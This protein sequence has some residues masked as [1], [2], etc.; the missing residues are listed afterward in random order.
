M[1]EIK[2]LDVRIVGTKNEEEE[3]WRYLRLFSQEKFVQEKMKNSHQEMKS[4]ELKNISFRISACIKHA[5]EY[6]SA[7]KSVSL[8]TKPLLLYY[9]M[10]SLAKALIYFRE[11]DIDTNSLKHH[12]LLYPQFDGTPEEFVNATTVLRPTGVFYHFS[13]YTQ[14]DYCYFMATEIQAGDIESSFYLWQKAELDRFSENDEFILE[15]LLKGIPELFDVSSLMGIIGME[16]Y[17]ISLDL[18]KNISGNW[19]RLLS[20]YKS[21]NNGFTKELLLTKF[22]ELR[23]DKEIVRETSDIISFDRS[24]YENWKTL[25]PT[26]LVQSTSGGKFL[27]SRDNQVSDMNANF[28]VMFILSNIVRYKP[29]LWQEILDTKYKIIVETLVSNSERKFPHLILNE[30]FDEIIVFREDM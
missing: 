10:Y 25:M 28:I 20:F 23:N 16:L 6:Y 29:P 15:E 5:E 26:E 24:L 30:L 18:E 3:L 21:K 12:G 9:G 27:A 19:N 2:D 7:A 14:H 1:G 4:D 8:S 11:P 17:K 22:P 13:K